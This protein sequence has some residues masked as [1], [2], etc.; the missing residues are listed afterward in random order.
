MVLIPSIGAGVHKYRFIN[1]IFMFT[2][3]M[4]LQ[5]YIGLLNPH[6]YHNTIVTFTVFVGHLS[7]ISVVFNLGYAYPRGYAK[8]S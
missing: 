5:C 1:I 7:S 8:I 3:F 2:F 4:L 6:E